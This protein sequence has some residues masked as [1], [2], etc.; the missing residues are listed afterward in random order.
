MTVTVKS[1]EKDQLMRKLE[2][3]LEVAG[4]DPSKEKEM[5]EHVRKLPLRVLRSL[6]YRIERSQS[7]TFEEGAFEERWR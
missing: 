4:T 5:Y 1:L 2:K 6:V 3:L 7:D